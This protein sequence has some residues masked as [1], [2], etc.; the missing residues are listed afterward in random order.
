MDKYIYPYIYSYEEL[1]ISL[2]NQ[3]FIDINLHFIRF[4]LTIL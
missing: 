2:L 3:Q 4:C 1:Q